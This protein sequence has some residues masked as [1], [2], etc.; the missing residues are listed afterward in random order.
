MIEWALAHP[1]MTF[2]IAVVALFVVDDVTV[3]ICRIFRR[4]KGGEEK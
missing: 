3:N 4:R 1:W 2:S